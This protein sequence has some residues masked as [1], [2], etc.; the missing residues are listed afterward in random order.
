MGGQ[1]TPPADESGLLFEELPLAD[2]RAAAYAI[3]REAEPI[4]RGDHGAYIPPG[5]GGGQ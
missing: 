5:G 4:A 2:S 1:A 3:V